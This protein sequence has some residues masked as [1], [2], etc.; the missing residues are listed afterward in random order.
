LQ[1]VD[2]ITDLV[3][4]AARKVIDSE[5][6]A[7]PMMIVETRSISKKI[8]LPANLESGEKREAVLTTV[9]NLQAIRAKAF[10]GGEGRNRSPQASFR[11]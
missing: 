11:G 1:W 5:I 7:H 3:W 6:L 4:V 10:I 2:S 9:E 8:E